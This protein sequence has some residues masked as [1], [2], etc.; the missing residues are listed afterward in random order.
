MSP[1][2]SIAKQPDGS[3]SPL[4][5]SGRIQVLCTLLQRMSALILIHI[6]IEKRAGM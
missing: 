5:G 4:F 6:R 2:F 3:A 1:G